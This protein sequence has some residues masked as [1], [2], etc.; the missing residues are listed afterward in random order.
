MNAALLVETVVPLAVVMAMLAVGLNLDVAAL[1]GSLRKPRSLL[2][3]TLLQIVL[4]PVAVLALIALISPPPLFSAVM[5]AVAISPGGTLSNA[6]THLVRGNLGLSVVMT[7]VTTLLVS[8]TAPAAV[9]L[10]T[11]TGGAG[12][13]PLGNLSPAAIAFDLVMVTLLPICCGVVLGAVLPGPVARARRTVDLLCA[14]AIV[15][16]VAS[17]AMVSWPVVR[18]NVVQY[19]LPAAAL[20]LVLLAAGGVVALLLPSSDRSASV[21]EFGTRNLPVAIILSSGAGASD[22]IVAFLLCHFVVNC[23]LLLALTLARR[24][25]G[26]RHAAPGPDRSNA[27]ERRSAH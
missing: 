4:L 23:T 10:A 16:V 24:R 21:I 7:I 15:V 6:I 2:L 11:W 18:L 14:L 25:A 5:F 3:C 13:A 22:A 1:R 9:A 19:V 27:G 12:I 17:S 26:R 20:S 8:V